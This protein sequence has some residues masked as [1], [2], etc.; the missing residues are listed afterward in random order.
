VSDAATPTG[1]PT[2]HLD[3]L[4]QPLIGV[5]TTI[6]SDGL[7]Q[8]TA[9]WFLLDEGELTMSVRTDRQKYRN[10]LANPNATLFI[11]DA[12]STSRTLEIRGE[13][14]IRPDPDKEHAAKFASVYGDAASAWDPEGVA[15]VVLV[16]TP[17]RVVAFG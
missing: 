3:L 13:I 14:E 10:L 12:Q 8:S 11:F 2:T 16:L 9:L 1:V 17:R 15:R 5:L 7:P 4:S 6:G